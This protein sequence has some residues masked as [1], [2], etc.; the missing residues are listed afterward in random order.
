VNPELELMA[1]RLTMAAEAAGCAS[2]ILIASLSKS[3]SQLRGC[4]GHTRTSQKR[5]FQ[6]DH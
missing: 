6:G 5:G 3:V 4:L 2:S 1:G